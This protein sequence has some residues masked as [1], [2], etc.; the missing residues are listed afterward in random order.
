MEEAQVA[1]GADSRDHNV[2]ALEI[3]VG[4]EGP[5]RDAYDELSK[6]LALQLIVR[7]GERQGDRVAME[8][9]HL[10]HVL[11]ARP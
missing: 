6:S 5:W 7:Y 9:E 4:R 11:H 10:G 3:N 8:V 2:E 1:S